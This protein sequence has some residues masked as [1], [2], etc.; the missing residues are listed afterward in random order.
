MR[1]DFFAQNVLIYRAEINQSPE[2]FL[3]ECYADEN[4]RAT[5]KNRLEDALWKDLQLR[6]LANGIIQ[7]FF[8]KDSPTSHE[9]K[10]EGVNK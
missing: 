7:G 4:F 1:K 9:A 10:K 6:D 8:I 2:D 5:Y 3:C